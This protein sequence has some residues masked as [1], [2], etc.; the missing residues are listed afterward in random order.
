LEHRS[1]VYVGGHLPDFVRQ[2]ITFEVSIEPKPDGGARGV[3]TV[4]NER[5]GHNFP[6]DS[7]NRAVDVV[8]RVENEGGIDIA[9]GD[10]FRFRN[11]YV[12]ERDKVNT[13][14]PS[15]EAKVLSVDLPAGPATF[16]A[17]LVYR[18]NP[19]EEDKDS[20]VLFEE[21]ADY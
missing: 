19:F 6:S 5:V 17:R 10:R 7:R 18:H 3:V 13:Q 9:A 16:V 14:P 1:H 8:Y 21:K 2:A 12:T 11:P 15:G 20:V 4:K